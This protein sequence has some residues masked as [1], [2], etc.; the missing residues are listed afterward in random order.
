[1]DYIPAAKDT[2]VPVDPR[3]PRRTS[4]GAHAKPTSVKTMMGTRPLPGNSTPTRRICNQNGASA[5]AYIAS[6]TEESV[7]R[8]AGFRM[9]TDNL[10]PVAVLRVGSDC[11]GIGGPLHMFGQAQGSKFHRSFTHVWP[12]SVF[13]STLHLHDQTTS[14]AQL[15]AFRLRVHRLGLVPRTSEY[16]GCLH[17]G[18][19]PEK[20]ALLDAM[21]SFYGDGSRAMHFLD[22]KHRDN[23][24]APQC[25][26][27]VS[28]APCPAWSSAGARAGLDDLKNGACSY[29]TRWTMSGIRSQEL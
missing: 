17:R 22:I 4:K 8:P 10:G 7:A 21:H 11:S 13:C 24:L 1:M 3:A 23:K 14:H 2:S 15:L 26:L 18:G 28:G 16:Q 9:G 29:S 6:L 27:F 25:D 19:R 12:S 5:A 20:K